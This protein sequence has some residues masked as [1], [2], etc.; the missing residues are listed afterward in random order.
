MFL[1][2]KGKMFREHQYLKTGDIL[3]MGKKFE[4]VCTENVIQGTCRLSSL[5]KKILKLD[6]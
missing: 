5:L 3:C 2:S 6:I 1:I 4:L